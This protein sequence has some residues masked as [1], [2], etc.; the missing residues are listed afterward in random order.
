[1]LDGRRIDLTL[2]RPIV[3]VR[4]DEHPLV[5][6]RVEAAMRVRDH[7][8]DTESTENTETE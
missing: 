4:R 3:A 8:Y 1:M 6:Q 7:R 2:P 5:T